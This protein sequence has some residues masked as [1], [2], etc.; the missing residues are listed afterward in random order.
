[1]AAAAREPSIFARAPPSTVE[2]AGAG[3]RGPDRTRRE[4]SIGTIRPI[5]AVLAPFNIDAGVASSFTP[6]IFSLMWSRYVLHRSQ[7]YKYRL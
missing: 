5:L 6:Y 4:E 7:M 1:M 2:A 3:Q